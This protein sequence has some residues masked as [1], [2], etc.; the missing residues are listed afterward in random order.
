MMRGNKLGTVPRP[1]AGVNN[2]P[3]PSV[4]CMGIGTGMVALQE[5]DRA[6]I[7]ANGIIRFRAKRAGASHWRLDDGRGRLGRH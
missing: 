5:W 4:L 1:G 3:T 7:V 6:W 2:T